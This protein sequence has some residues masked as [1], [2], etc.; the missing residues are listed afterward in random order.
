MHKKYGAAVGADGIIFVISRRVTIYMDFLLK[1]IRSCIAALVFIVAADV[2]AQSEG[3]NFDVSLITCEPGTEAYSLYGHT[4]VRVLSHDKEKD[5]V[6][7][8]GVFSFEDNNFTWNFIMGKPEYT[9][10]A[11]PTSFFLEEYEATGRAVREQWLNLDGDEKLR[12]IVRM[13]DDATRRGW[14]YRYNIFRDNCTSR[15][16]RMLA[17]ATDGGLVLPEDTVR[18]TFREIVDS[19]AGRHN[20]WPSFGIDLLLGAEVDT[21]VSSLD[22]IAFP[23]YAERLLDGA[24]FKGGDGTL[25]VAV[26]EKDVL[27]KAGEK[28]DAV[29]V[30][31]WNVITPMSVSVLILL[32]SIFCCWTRWRGKV[33]PA[34]IFD[35]VMMFVLGVAGL[36]VGMIFFFS[37]HPSVDSNR[38]ITLLN[39]LPLFWLPVKLWRDRKGLGDAYVP[40]VQWLM[41]IAFYVCAP[42]QQV[43]L[44]VYVVALA[45]LA[46]TLT[47]R[48]LPDVEKSP[49]RL[50][51][52]AVLAISA[53]VITVYKFFV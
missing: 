36:V 2:S 12:L 9:C 35:D 38:L 25:R 7:N 1:I 51:L 30:G 18:T 6:F 8:Y 32:L 11:M 24:A 52:D 49:W 37:E 43:P 15:V 22:E 19:Y 31:I 10:M 47:E 20:P 27:F 44:A 48:N 28:Q 40:W 17:D 13:Q 50:R 39:P 29:S 14:T 45:L 4:A 53:I 16:I 34:R 33:L 5:V 3:D 23:E 42:T 26:R 21:T 46:R 41:L